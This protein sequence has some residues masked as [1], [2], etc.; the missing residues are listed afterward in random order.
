M[1]PP[2]RRAA[3]RPL[4]SPMRLLLSA[5]FAIAVLYAALLVGRMRSLSANSVSSRPAFFAP[6]KGTLF[7]ASSGWWTALFTR[8]PEVCF[9]VRVMPAHATNTPA[10]IFSI[11]A[12][13]YP[14]VRVILVRTYAARLFDN[15]F[16]TIADYINAALP[17]PRV[18]V[19]PL[20]SDVTEATWPGIARGVL[21][22]D[23][24]FPVT[25][26]VMESIVEERRRRRGAGG[27]NARDNIGYCDALVVTNG[28]NLYAH[29]FLPAVVKELVDHDLV[30]TFFTSR[31]EN[32]PE[33]MRRAA[34]RGRIGGPSRLGR[35]Y[36]FNASFTPGG[37]DLGAV[38][39]RTDLVAAHGVRFVVDRLRADPTGAGIDFVEADGD[40]HQKLSRLPGTRSTIIERSLFVHQ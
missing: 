31:Y 14:H 38:I 17:E 26:L 18:E 3:P 13:A 36:E 1:L 7:A 27:R 24:G 12:S 9:V 40:F 29:E 2:A 16:S 37:I 19:S 5:A 21:T 4:C 35:D 15:I 8:E 32:T 33:L 25:D 6:F 28:D 30:G 34:R 22:G 23:G 39:F 20:D 11:F 10:L